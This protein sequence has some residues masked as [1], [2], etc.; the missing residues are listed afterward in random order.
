MAFAE[1][2]CVQ[3][4]G[5]KKD[6]NS[7]ISLQSICCDIVVC[8]LLFVASVVGLLCCVLFWVWVCSLI[9]M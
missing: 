5:R 4:Q 8:L 7:V 1:F 3:K 9:E 2:V 6:V